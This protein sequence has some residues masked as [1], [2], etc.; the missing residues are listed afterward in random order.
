MTARKSSS[1]TLRMG[2]LAI[3]ACSQAIAAEPGRAERLIPVLTVAI[4]S[5]RPPEARAGLSAILSAVAARPELEALL[6]RYLPELRLLPTE[7]T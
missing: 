7:A 1:R 4:R 6:T 5:V 3:L 2:V